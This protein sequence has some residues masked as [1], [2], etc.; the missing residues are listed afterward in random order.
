MPE[1]NYTEEELVRL[2]KEKSKPAFS[3]LYD[4]YS[5]A[6]YGIVLRILTNDEETSQDILQ[7]SFVKIWKNI[8]TYDRSKGTLFTWM[9]NVTRHTAIDKLRTLKRTAIQSID[10]NVYNIDRQHSHKTNEDNIGVKEM[11]NKLKPEYKIIIDLA[12]FGGYTQ[13]E[14]SEELKMPLGTV[15]TRARA[16]LIEL[17]KIIA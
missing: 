1:K 8:E 5:A 11:V 9:L 14:I 17:R 4:N 15:K 3:Y 16:A 7:E 6:L 10:D 12:Y 2:L 13:E